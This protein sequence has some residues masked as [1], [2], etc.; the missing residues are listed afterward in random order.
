LHHL[1]LTRSSLKP[2]HLLQTP[3]TFVRTP[4]PG[5]AGVEFIVHASPRLG[6]RFTQMTAEFAPKGTLGPAP[7]Q[8]FLY[9]LSGE[10]EL[11]LEGKHHLLGPGGYAYIPQFTPHHVV[12]LGSARA[13]LIEKPYQDSGGETTH[14]APVVGHEAAVSDVP[15]MGDESLRVRSLMPDSPAYDFAVNT[16]TYDPGASLSMIEI[17]IMEHGLLM[18]EGGGIYRLGDSWY[19]VQ[20]GD[21]IWMAPYCPQ[22]F[23]ALGKRPAKYLIYKDWR[24][25]PLGV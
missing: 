10:L 18:L 13:A 22:W 7:A 11:T 4:L 15:L 8:R 21:F 2:D 14:P 24:R 23:G 6:A 9:V 12:A 20:A 25:H 16:M 17:H 5:A 3:D 19:P 1:G